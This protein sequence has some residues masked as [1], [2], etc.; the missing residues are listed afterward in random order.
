M[1]ANV[2]YIFLSFFLLGGGSYLHAETLPD[3]IGYSF[4]NNLVKKEQVKHKNSNRKSV[5]IEEADIDLDEEFHNVDE[6]KI[7]GDTKFL[8]PTNNFLQSWYLNLSNHYLLNSNS[9][10]TKTL[11]PFRG[12]S[13]RIY[14]TQ[15]VL[16]I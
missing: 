9:K 7:G 6:Y 12:Q 8:V 15:S 16:R 5:V 10:C 1:K 11:V 13:N 3:H 14:I 2:F 4:S